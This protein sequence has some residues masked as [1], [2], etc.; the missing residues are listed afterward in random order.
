MREGYE[1]YP[2]RKLRGRYNVA[3]ICTSLNINKIIFT[4]LLSLFFCLF[5][6]GGAWKRTGG[7]AK[8]RGWVGWD[9]QG[10]SQHIPDKNTTLSYCKPCRSHCSACSPVFTVGY[11]G[12]SEHE[13]FAIR[14]KKKTVCR[15]CF[16]PVYGTKDRL[17]EGSLL[18]RQCKGATNLT[19]TPES[20]L[21]FILTTKNAPSVRSKL[22][23]KL[24]FASLVCYLLVRGCMKC[25]HVAVK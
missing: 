4:C 17:G 1:G 8:G 6:F 2:I 9:R 20:Y 23:A 11:L 10:T 3:V 21:V 24:V 25:T 7:Q 16:S 19:G 14:Q 15:G 5:V 18:H 13:T 22:S 12:P